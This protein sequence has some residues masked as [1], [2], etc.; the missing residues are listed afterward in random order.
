MDH[1]TEGNFYAVWQIKDDLNREKQM[2][3]DELYGISTSMW[4]NNGSDYDKERTLELSARVEDINRILDGI[5]LGYY[6][7]P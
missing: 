7:S 4:Q 2:I 3:L 6:R 5:R 1:E